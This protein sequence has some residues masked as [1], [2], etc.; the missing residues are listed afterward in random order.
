MKSTQDKFRLVNDGKMLKKDFLTEVKRAHRNLITQTTTYKDAVQILKNK[1]IVNEHFLGLQTTKPINSNP[2]WFK[3]F[4]SNMVEEDV[5]AELK[6]TDKDVVELETK[7]YDYKDP[8]NVDNVYG[9]SFLQGYY[10]ELKNPKNADK[11]EVELKEIVAKNI[12]SNRLYYTEEAQ[13]GIEGIGYTADAPGLAASKSDQMVPVKES[14]LRKYRKN[15][16]LLKEG[17]DKQFVDDFISII[18]SGYDE[19]EVETRVHRDE[20]MDMNE[21]NDSEGDFDKI[22]DLVEKGIIEDPHWEMTFT[23]GEEYGDKY[24]DVSNTKYLDK[25]GRSPANYQEGKK[26]LKESHIKLGDLLKEGWVNY[27]GEGAKVNEEEDDITVHDDS[28]VDAEELKQLGETPKKAKKTTLEARLREIESLGKS[29][30]LEA[31]IQAVSEE[32]TTRMDKLNVAENMEEVAE[33]INPVRV[34]EMKKDIKLL[35]K[36]KSF[37]EKLYKRETKEDYRAPIVDEDMDSLYEAIPSVPPIPGRKEIGKID[38]EYS[39]KKAFLPDPKKKPDAPG[40]EG[41]A[42]IKD[43]EKEKENKAGGKKGLEVMTADFNDPIRKEITAAYAAF[44][45]WQIEYDKSLSPEAKK[46]FDA[47]FDKIS[48]LTTKIQGR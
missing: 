36:K 31:K 41:I 28:E 1:N 12:E 16:R 14:K 30:A 11:T 5:K 29:I 2:D 7:G 42:K 39:K 27:G 25:H 24:I 46:E 26:T 8:K 38:A 44:D 4:N 20:W 40:R 22:Y 45:D 18:F 34:K 47:A 35:E 19:E 15:N 10:T 32:I 6:K 37:Y 17:Y 13:F 3:I 48:K 43:S 33:F 23:I 9:E 21:D